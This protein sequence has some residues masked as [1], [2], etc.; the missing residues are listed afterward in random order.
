MAASLVAVNLLGGGQVL[1]WAIPGYALLSLGAMASAIPVPSHDVS[2]RLLVCLGSAFVFFGYILVR[3]LCSPVDYL[4]RP[5]LEMVLGALIVYLLVSLNFTDPRRRTWVVAIVLALAVANCVVGAIQYVKMDDFMPFASIVRMEGGSRASGFFVN[6]N[7]LAGFLE[8][9]L[10]MGM[11][12][13][14]FSRWKF[15]GKILAGYGSLVCV[16]GIVMTGS[17]GGYL[18]VCAGLL[19][20][21][22][23][24]LIV[25]GD[26]LRER[27]LYVLGVM[28][29]LGLAGGFLVTQAMSRDYYLSSRIAT[30]TNDPAR[31][32]YTKAALAQF[33]TSPMFG[34]GSGTYLYLSRQFRGRE[35]GGKDAVYAHN[36]YLQLLAEFGIVGMAGFLLFLLI[37]LRNGWIS[38]EAVN[39]AQTT[40]VMH[41]SNSLALTVGALSTIGAYVVH[42]YVDFNLHIPANTL[43]MA[44]VFGVMAT[45][46]YSGMPGVELRTGSAL[47][48]RYA[49]LTIPIIG[50]W[51]AWMVLG[52]CFGEYYGEKARAALDDFEFQDAADQ[53][54]KALRYEHSN[55][56]LF[57]DLGEAKTGLAESAADQDEKDALYAEALAAY[58][59]GLAL[60]PQDER[61]VLCVGWTLDALKRFDESESVFRRAVS[62]DPNSDET[63]FHYGVHLELRGQLAEA[64][65]QYEEARALGSESAFIALQRLAED[66]KAKPAEPAI[67]L[68]KEP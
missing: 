31:K 60:F 64:K 6:P 25:V 39:A 47:R 21:G 27:L 18:S 11:A 59:K 56:N 45:P 19:V 55:P 14:F 1:V 13:T 49:R 17:R 50:V 63:R 43:A 58:K 10:F 3:T 38:L 7:H 26:V 62:M 68:Q 40:S 2:N 61:L 23:L 12:V 57:Y 5:D 28:L 15:W 46:G 30:I 41:G 37:H 48:R 44:F 52:S 34:T 51:L 9:A 29:V 4:A 33:Q 35:A 36:D 66:P 24:S 8:I 32:E 54:L 53:A 67:M 22:F 42:S 20:F 65:A 16:A